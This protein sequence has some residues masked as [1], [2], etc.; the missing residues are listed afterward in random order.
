MK[1]KKITENKYEI[2]MCDEDIIKKRNFFDLGE[3]GDFW[4]HSIIVETNDEG[5]ILC[6]IVLK[7]LY[8]PIGGEEREEILD[9]ILVDTNDVKLEDIISGKYTA[10]EI[11]KMEWDEFQI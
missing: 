5:Y 1:Y 7:G 8:K 10:G 4:A 6:N 3:V 11:A 2:E 9:A